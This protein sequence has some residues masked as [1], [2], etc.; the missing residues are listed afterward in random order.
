MQPV[1]PANFDPLEYFKT[2]PVDLPPTFAP[3]KHLD[4]FMH[5]QQTKPYLAKKHMFPS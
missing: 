1:F 4:K 2:N 3:T 5:D